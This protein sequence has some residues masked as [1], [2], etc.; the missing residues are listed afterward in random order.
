VH[1]L[2]LGKSLGSGD[3][4][5]GD[6]PLRED[7]PDEIEV[8]ATTLGDVAPI[9]LL[10]LATFIRWHVAQGRA[11]TLKW[12]TDP[13]VG[14]HLGRM[15]LADC[16]PAE[17]ISGFDGRVPPA[18]NVVL[19]ITQIS[20]PTEIDALAD[21]LLDVITGHA[22][23]VAALGPAFHMAV[24]ELCGN[25]VEHG[26]N[27]TGAFVTAQRY[28]EPRRLSLAIADLG[29]GIPEHVRQQFP[30]WHDDA[31]AIASATQERVSGTGSSDRGFGFAEIFR[32]GLATAMNAAEMNI[33][34]CRGQVRI[35][36]ADDRVV[37][38]GWATP[39]KRGS[40][41]SYEL[42]AAG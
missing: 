34:S 29:V 32:E 4:W 21:P 28:E 22:G 31:G 20:R 15:G 35:K 40:W 2:R 8:D 18:D 39:Y 16:L 11:V 42:V 6:L 25:A 37:P 38:A 17:S 36:V 3:G 10:R 23:T 19:P 30:E 41:I 24:S 13:H 12:P 26:A 33:R 5:G 27:P 9:F 7:Y 14:A 1:V